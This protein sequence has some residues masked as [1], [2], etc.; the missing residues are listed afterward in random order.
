MYGSELVR[1]LV[2][3]LQ[4]VLVPEEVEHDDFDKIIAKLDSYFIP[5]INLDSFH[6]KFAKMYQQHGESIAQYYVRLRNW[7]YKCG[8][9][10][11]SDVI[12]CTILQTMIDGRLRR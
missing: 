4:D 6:S 7:A 1:E 9:V 5:L 12:Q 3:T 11:L 10:D 8:I 2:N